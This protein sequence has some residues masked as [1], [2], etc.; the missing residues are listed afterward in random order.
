MG[1]DDYIE[2][3][4]DGCEEEREADQED[5]DDYLE[6]RNYDPPTSICDRLA[7]PQQLKS[8]GEIKDL[9][10]ALGYELARVRHDAPVKAKRLE[11]VSP[12]RMRVSSMRM[13]LPLAN[14]S[15]PSLSMSLSL[16]I[17]RP[18]GMQWNR[19]RPNAPELAR[20]TRHRSCGLCG[21]HRWLFVDCEWMRSK[22]E[23]SSPCCV[24]SVVSVRSA[25][26]FGMV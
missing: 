2:D 5:I 20:K 16:G 25:S 11:R 26:C 22:L 9:I 8:S 23:K 13:R 6:P 14:V 21:S 10:D 18:D 4:E 19:M 1:N 7:K 12:V 17:M 15:L 24:K 3:Y